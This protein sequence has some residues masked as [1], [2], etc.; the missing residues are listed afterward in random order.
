M[1]YMSVVS[2]EKYSLIKNKIDLQGGPENEAT[3][4]GHYVWLLTSHEPICM[5]FDKLQCRFVL[6]TS[7]YS[8]SP[9]LIKFITRVRCSEGLRLAGV[10]R[11]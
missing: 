9:N 6:K 8:V 4:L 5:I 7:V 1:L 2:Y 3:T 10:A 11:A